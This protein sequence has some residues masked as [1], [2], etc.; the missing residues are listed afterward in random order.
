VHAY[1]HGLQHK[2]DPEPDKPI[3]GYDHIGTY[4]DAFY[5]RYFVKPGT[6]SWPAS[7]LHFS[8]RASAQ[9]FTVTYN[10]DGINGPRV[11]KGTPGP[12]SNCIPNYSSMFNAGEL[13]LSVCLE[14][15]GDFL[16]G[17]VCPAGAF[18]NGVYWNSCLEPLNPGT[19]LVGSGLETFYFEAGSTGK[20]A[21]FMLASDDFDLEESIASRVMFAAWNG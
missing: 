10:I 12:T 3:S 9:P 18:E 13:G 21:T 7:I 11:V 5:V 1:I 2:H 15:V 6:A 20:D 8:R 19:V 4:D 16:G 14:A 17:A